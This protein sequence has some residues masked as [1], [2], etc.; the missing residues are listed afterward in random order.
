MAS[1]AFGSAQ[2]KIFVGKQ[3]V[4]RLAPELINKPPHELDHHCL[5]D[6]CGRVFSACGDLFR[7]LV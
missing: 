2:P 7:A 1:A 4:H 3:A 5:V 6:E